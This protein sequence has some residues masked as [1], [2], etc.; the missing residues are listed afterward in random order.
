MRDN[1]RDVLAFSLGYYAE[2]YKPI[3]GTGASAFGINYGS[4]GSDVAGKPLYNGNISTTTLALSKFRGGD[5]VGYSY[6]YD[7]LN[8]L[9]EMRQH[10]LTAA[11]TTW[12]SASAGEPYKESYSYDA[13]GN[14]LSLLRNGTTQAG[15]PLQMDQLTYNY[16]PNTNKLAYVA[17]A[18]GDNNYTEDIDNQAVGNYRYDKI[19]NLIGDVKEGLTDIQWSVYGKIRSIT[20]AGGS[21]ISY[22]YDAAGNRIAKSVTTGG[23]TTTTYYIRDA[24]GNTLAVYEGTAKKEQYLYGSSRLGVY[25]PALDQRSYELTNHLGNVLA[26]VSEHKV[27]TASGN[28]ADVLSQQ[29]YYPFGMGLPDRKWG[30]SYRYGFNGKEHDPEVK[31]SGAQYDY[32]FRVYDPRLGKFLSI[33]PLT[34]NYPFYTPYQFAG[35]KPIMAI[36]L[37]GL[38]EWV[39]IFVNGSNKPTTFRFAP[40]LKPLGAGQIYKHTYDLRTGASTSSIYEVNKKA[41]INVAFIPNEKLVNKDEEHETIEAMSAYSYDAEFFNGLDAKSEN[42]A[43]IGAG[44]LEEMVFKGITYAIENNVSFKDAII[45]F[46]GTQHF[47]KRTD[48]QPHKLEFGENQ[49]QVDANGVPTNYNEKTSHLFQ[50]LGK[51][52][53]EG[54]QTLMGHC[55]ANKCTQVLQLISKDMNTTVYGHKSYSYSSNLKNGRFYGGILNWMMSQSDGNGANQGKYLKVTPDGTTTSMGGVQFSTEKKTAGNISTVND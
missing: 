41:I 1:A 45:D 12:G 5:P 49:L 29:D 32:G 18:I 27:T 52:R 28:E 51:F 50:L 22:S 24:Q 14:I 33:D 26:V 44:N 13:N 7:Q 43:A 54:S 3:G 46:H 8:R 47:E 53:S 16:L 48:G 31:G 30:N 36:D 9:K 6:G 35:N 42:F 23:V 4:Q 39:A 21:T 25:D 15:K 2:D 17:D 11:T 37:D 20:K 38:E 40:E 10:N 34:K 55:N 19:G